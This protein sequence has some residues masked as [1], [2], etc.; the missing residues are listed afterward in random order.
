[1]SG[2]LA[3]DPEKFW[4]LKTSANTRFCSVGRVGR[5]NGYTIVKQVQSRRA[6]PL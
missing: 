6:F 3:A 5:L 4:V 1:V 2:N